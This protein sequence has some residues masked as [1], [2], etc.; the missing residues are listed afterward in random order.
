MNDQNL[1][2]Q[3]TVFRNAYLRLLAD[4]WC[5]PGLA[6]KI[7]TTAHYNPK[8]DSDAHQY[9]VKPEDEIPRELFVN[10]RLNELQIIQGSYGALDQFNVS[11][12]DTL[13][14]LLPDANGEM[15]S[16][17]IAFRHYLNG[18]EF[19]WL[20]N[21]YLIDN[22]F[23]YYSPQKPHFR[24][25]W[26][27]G[28]DLFV[29]KIPNRPTDDGVHAK[30]LMTY[31][32]I[33]PTIFGT[34]RGV[35]NIT[36]TNPKGNAEMDIQQVMRYMVDFMPD[37]ANFRKAEFINLANDL[38]MGGMR[39]FKA[40]SG[41]LMQMIA[42]AWSH[43]GYF[44]YLTTESVI[45]PV[46]TPQSVYRDEFVEFRNPWSFNIIF[47]KAEDS[48]WNDN[49]WTNLEYTDIYMNYP[50]IPKSAMGQFNSGKNTYMNAGA[51]LDRKAVSKAESFW[52]AEA[53]ARYNNTGPEYPFS[54]C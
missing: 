24:N 44:N 20:A 47:R 4:S 7:T 12:K 6:T 40:F 38:G 42:A 51:D 30:A 36:F 31:Y 46:G 28:S 18:F 16:A 10:R 15:S 29:I 49:S 45:T 3:L 43:D 52:R 2:R 17:A 35:P 33:F 50:T 53:I 48:A 1:S 54:C 39:S 23:L 5:K 8:P 27:G 9:R 41:V 14:G 22:H 25:G 19:D 32:E 34:G 26:S 21:V 13:K 11:E 37:F